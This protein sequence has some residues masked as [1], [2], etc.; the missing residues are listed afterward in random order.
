MSIW[1]TKQ[2]V[3]ALDQGGVIAYPTEAIWGL[4]CNPWDRAAVMHLLKLKQRPVDKGLILIAGDISQLGDLL[5][6]LSESERLLLSQPRSVPTTWIIPDRMRVIPTWVKGLHSDVAVRVSTHL[7]VKQLCHYYDGMLVS[8]SANISSQPP[9]R[10]QREVRAAF[11]RSL[12]YLLPG[13]LGG[14][15]RPSEIRLLKTGAV[16]RSG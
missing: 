6:G 11:G 13:P 12:N 5:L 15:N 2:A 14:S 7:G 1:H 10:T 3:R 16:L 8:T 4:G 9:A